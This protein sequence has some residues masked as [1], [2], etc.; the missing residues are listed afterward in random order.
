MNGVR[1]VEGQLFGEHSS[2]QWRHSV[3]ST[4]SAVLEMQIVAKGFLFLY[5]ISIR[6]KEFRVDGA[7]SSEP[8]NLIDLPL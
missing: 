6:I 1:D 4:R 5:I 2:S 8:S 7:S 3:C